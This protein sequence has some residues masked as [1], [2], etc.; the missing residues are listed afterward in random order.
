MADTIKALAAVGEKDEFVSNWEYEPRP[1]Q[2]DDVDVRITAAGVCHSD[3]HQVKKEWKGV[4]QTRP[5]VPGHEIVGVV[6]RAG[7]NARHKVGTRVA[8]GTIV[9][10]C[11]KCDMCNQQDEVYCTKV[12]DT[13]QGTHAATKTRCHGGFAER[14]IVDSKFAY[15]VPADLPSTTAAPLM[16]AGVTVYA[17]LKRH[18]TPGA[19]VGVVGIGGLGH[20]ALQFARALGYARVVALSTSADKAAAAKSFGAHDVLVTTD[21]AQMGPAGNSFDLLLVTVSADLSW[22][23][24]LRLLKVG[25]TL[26]LVGL[27]PSDMKINPFA[28]LGRRVN[29]TGSSTGGTK[30][31]AEMLQVAAQ[32]KVRAAVELLPLDAK[33][34]NEAFDR[35]SKNL[36]RYRCVLIPKDAPKEG[37]DL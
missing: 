25:G 23:A 19:T 2:P 31:T 6:I 4:K 10:S 33:G 8:V 26:C 29:L 34:A 15:Q 22:G 3:L 35:I 21:R 7:P 11:G 36:P 14:V 12:V 32:H 28:L 13:Y 16:C 24:Y 17:P 9:G 30:I 37:G 5:M 20:F 18:F 27:P 1:L